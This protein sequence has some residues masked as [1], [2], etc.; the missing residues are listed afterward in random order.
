VMDLCGVPGADLRDFLLVEAP[1]R[2]G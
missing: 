1:K 2:G